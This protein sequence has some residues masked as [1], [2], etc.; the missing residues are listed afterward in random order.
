MYEIGSAG[1][2]LSKERSIFE[3]PLFG[4]NLLLT[5]HC[6]FKDALKFQIAFIIVKY[7]LFFRIVKTQ[8]N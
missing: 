2:P 7:L 1:D 4:K 3:H 5:S 8:I 6:T